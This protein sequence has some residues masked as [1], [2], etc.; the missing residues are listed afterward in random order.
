VLSWN[1]LHYLRATLAS[2]RRCLRYPELEWIVS[3]NE[4][5]EPDLRE[6]IESCDGVSHRIFKSQAHAEAMNRIVDLAG[7]EYL[8]LWPDDVQL[9]VEQEWTG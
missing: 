6:R 1:R 5:T 4:S 9:V 8:I 3:D 7:R 2:V